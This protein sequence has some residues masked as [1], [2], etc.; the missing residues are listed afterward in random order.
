M[1]PGKLPWNPEW[2]GYLSDGLGGGS[3]VGGREVHHGEVQA[4]PAAAAAGHRRIPLL[5]K[6]RFAAAAAAAVRVRV[7]TVTGFTEEEANMA[8]LR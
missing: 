7:P 2:I 3:G 4:I 6:R 5:P 8:H 1:F